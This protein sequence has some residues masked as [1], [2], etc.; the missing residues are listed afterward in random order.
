MSY[1]REHRFEIVWTE[2]AVAP[3]F[4]GAKVVAIAA[5][6]TDDVAV[7]VSA[8]VAAEHEAVAAAAAAESMAVETRK[9]AFAV[10][11]E[12]SIAAV[13]DAAAWRLLPISTATTV[14]STEFDTFCK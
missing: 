8:A 2:D 9:K 13:A 10:A 12:M 14:S 4:A 11:P 3:A 1:P 6:E 7:A 5:G